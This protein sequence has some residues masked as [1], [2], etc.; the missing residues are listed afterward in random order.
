MASSFIAYVDES[1]DEGF[2]FNPDGTGSSRWFVL[3]AVVFR[4]PNDL[5]AVGA[6]KRARETLKWDAKQNFHFTKMKHHQRLVLLHELAPLSFRTVTVVSYKPD[7]P[8]LERYQANKWLL[9]RYLT[10]LLIER[11][12]WLCRDHA[13]AGQGDGTVDLIFSDRAAMSYDDIRGYMNLLKQHA[14]NGSAAVNIHWPA[15]RVDQLRAVAH[16]QLAGLQLADVVA[17]SYFQAIRLNEF[18][19]ADPSYVGHLQKQVYRHRRAHLGYGLK[20]LSRYDELE[21]KM[22]HLRAAFGNW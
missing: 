17:S 16:D 9:Y 14:E 1:G 7:I 15:I 11:I 3:S 12:S 21:E 22:P 5:L 2:K 8:D 18:N 4:K 20:F 10:R 13:K 19:I 6:L